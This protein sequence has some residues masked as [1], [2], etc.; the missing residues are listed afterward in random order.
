MKVPYGEGLGTHT[1]PESCVHVCK[2]M[3][4]ALTG[5]VRARLWSHERYCMLRGCRRCIPKR[6]ATLVIS[7]SR[8][9]AGPCVVKDPVHA[10]FSRG[11]REILRLAS[12]DGTEVRA[13]IPKGVRQ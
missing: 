7:L 9:M 4:E 11:N 10:R 6:K 8:D 2:G 3:G 5:D 1:G 12:G 13:V